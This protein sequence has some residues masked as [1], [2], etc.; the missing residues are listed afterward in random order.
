[1]ASP[2]HAPDLRQPALLLEE[3]G[4]GRQRGQMLRRQLAERFPGRLADEVED[5]VQT[6]C[7]KFLGNADAAGFTE[8]ARAYAWLRTA[9]YREMVHE[10]EGQTRTIA[11]DPTGS[12]LEGEA[13]DQPGPVAELMEIEEQTELE[14]LVEEVASKLSDSRRRV[15][16]LWAAGRKRPEIAEQLGLSDRAVKKAL[17]EVMRSAR[18]VLTSRTGGGCA[19]GESL[20]LR[21]TCGLA[22]AGEEVRARLHLQHCGRCSTFSEELAAWKD[23]VP[24]VLPPVAV[25]VARPGLLGRAVGRVG[26]AVGSAR[27]HVLG[28]GSQIKQ[29]ATLATYGR[30]P[31]PTPLIGTRP[32]TVAAVVAGCLAIGGGAATICSQPGVDPLGAA[33]DLISGT[34]G[35]AAKEP[36]PPKAEEPAAPPAAEEPAEEPVVGPV[37]GAEEA[38]ESQPSTSTSSETQPHEESSPTEHE[39]PAVEPAVSEP[40]EVV[41]EEASPPPAEQSFEPASPEYPAVES[42][43]S[44]SSSGSSS[45]PS[46]PSSGS[47]SS[48]SA[49]KA[50]AV[51]KNEATQFGGP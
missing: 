8:P 9:A 23:R 3:F 5:A 10:L 16:A 43:S 42:S 4:P 20:V 30:T 25:E 27:R 19:E 22:A 12:L 48:S 31:D 38:T 41:V 49:A 6:A 18:E 50:A 47:E 51:P 1:M 39:Q 7:Q 40:E 45:S 37:Y 34:S 28:G 17:E 33:K 29:Q 36:T 11:A 15:F 14:I 46:T 13:S 35:E 26:E 2:S 21:L 44:S 32:G 24:A